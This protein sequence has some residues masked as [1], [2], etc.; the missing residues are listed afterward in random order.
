MSAA[1]LLIA[2]SG[3]AL[4]IGAFIDDDGNVHESEIEAVAAAG[5]T[6][7]CNPPD[8]DRYCPDG[9]VTRG[10]MATFLTRALTL[11][12]TTTNPFTDTTTSPHATDIATLAAAG[13]TKGCNPPDNDR[14]CPDDPVIRGQMATLLARGFSLEPPQVT[15]AAG[16]DIGA[17]SGT[18]ATLQVMAERGPSFF[19]ALG[20][21]GYRALEPESEWC[22]YILSWLGPDLPIEVVVG[23]HED[24]DGPD[25]DIRRFAECLPDRM[26]S[27][28]AY[29]SEYYFD[30]GDGLARIIMLGADTQVDGVDLDYTSDRLAR[31]GDMIDEARGF[32]VQWV[33]VGFHKP[34]LTAA[35]K[36]CEVGSDLMNLMIEKRVD[37]VLNGHDHTYQ[38]SHQLSCATVDVYRSECVVE[39][40]GDGTLRRGRGTI[41]VIT[42]LM[43]A[44]LYEIDPEDR[45]FG[46]FAATLGENDPHEGHGYFEVTLSR[47]K[48]TGRFIG[49]TTRFDDIFTIR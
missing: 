40:N 13:I 16:G 20:D 33:I 2:I 22:N 10:Q 17:Y 11:T 12:P 26:D 7:G 6:K 28:G 48:L 23:N 47:D 25:G 35:T 21:L 19:L 14:Y 18:D 24:D 46:Y 44:G 3:A 15:F 45:E 42:G 43:G 8:N 5:I 36:S 49:S 29:G 31:V 30:V 37:L 39:A 9:P 41:F 4:A 34:C 32:G 27:V 1:L 38:R